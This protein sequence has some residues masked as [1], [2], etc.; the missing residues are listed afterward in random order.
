M[1]GL[2]LFEMN[3]TLKNPMR[4]T[5]KVDIDKVQTLVIN[6]YLYIDKINKSL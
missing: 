1:V 2:F 3:R 6:V 4:Y 5:Q